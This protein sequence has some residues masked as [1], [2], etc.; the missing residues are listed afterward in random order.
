[1]LPRGRQGG[2]MQHHATLD[3][4]RHYPSLIAGHAAG[5]LAGSQ[6]SGAATLISTCSACS[7]LHRD[8][9]AIAT[10]S[11]ALPRDARAPRDFRLSAEQAASLRRG[12]WLRAMLRPFASP[13]SSAR[14]LAAAFT[15]VGAAGL[16][17][18]AFM[19]GMLGG[20]AGGPTREGDFQ[21]AQAPAPSSATEDSVG[22]MAGNPESTGDQALANGSGG[23]AAVPGDA[24]GES[25]PPEGRNGT[26]DGVA[27]PNPTNVLLVGSLGLLLVGIS[28]FG[29][30]FAARRVR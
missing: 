8:L 22:P 18:A 9:V 10:A 3:H 2:E 12:S 6:A 4:A 5:D 24:S 20:V 7:D 1:M 13:R 23:L 14:P 19:P 30:R 16:L 28:I 15:S 29:L 27:E 11:R 25:A 21:A 26:D 17:V